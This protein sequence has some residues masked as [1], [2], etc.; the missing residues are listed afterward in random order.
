MYF[1]LGNKG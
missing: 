1:I